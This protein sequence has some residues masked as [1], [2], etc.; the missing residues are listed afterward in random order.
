M[1]GILGGTFDPV[2]FGHLRPALD[3]LQTLGLDEVRL[4]P[5]NVAVHRPQP[6]ATPAMRLRML[7]AAVAGQPG[8][9]VDSREL[10]R[11][12]SSYSYDTLVSL[13][14]ELGATVPLCLL[15]GNDAFAEFLAW[16]RPLD[17]LALAHLIVM[18]RAGHEPVMEPLLTA[19]TLAYRCPDVRSL[20]GLAGGRILFQDVTQMTV[21]STRIRQLIAQGRSPRYL[22]PDAV[23]ELI[24]HA[25]VYR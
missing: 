17:I 12:G 24:E 20:A 4:I 25:G 1:I 11:P 18:R 21:S 9:N 6:L 16:H 7:A 13:R 2:H 8:L 23:L 14:A 15:V 19:L 10:Q 3:C 5:L 22:L